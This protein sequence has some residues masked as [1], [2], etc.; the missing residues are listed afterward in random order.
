MNTHA[1]LP[2]FRNRA[3]RQQQP[4]AMEDLRSEIDRLFDYFT[5]GFGRDLFAPLEPI[6]FGSVELMPSMD[7]H[8]TDTEVRLNVEL[9]GVEEKDIDISVSDQMLTVSG[10]KKTEAESG[11]GESYRSE[12]RYGRFSRSVSLPF[13]IDGDKVS[14]RFSKGVLAITMPKPAEVSARTRKIPISA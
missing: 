6:G 5:R 12:R 7:L 1:L 2:W 4:A 8:E 10:E 14:A 13:P 9:P 11:E 3:D